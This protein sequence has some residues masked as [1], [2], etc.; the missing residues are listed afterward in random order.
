[1]ILHIK[2]NGKWSVY[3]DVLEIRKTSFN[4]L[5]RFKESYVWEGLKD[6]VEDYIITKE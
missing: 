1:M 5:W 3:A 6:K 4:F 2:I